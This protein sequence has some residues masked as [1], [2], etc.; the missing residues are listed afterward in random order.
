MSIHYKD[1]ISPALAR[2]ARGVQDK[3]PILEAMGLQLVSL[4]QRAFNEAALRPA[5]WPAK[6]DGTPAT[7][8]KNQVLVRS[9]RITEITTDS[10]TV[11]TDRPYAAIHQRG[12]VIKPK[13]PDGVLVFEIGG[14]K[15][16][17]KRVVMPARPFFPF[18]GD[19]MTDSAQA[20]IRRVAEEKIASLA[21]GTAP[22][23][24]VA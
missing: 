23:G 16:F 20:K 17:A 2:L 8:R 11:A 13:R 9:I 10:V 1:T 19:R 6:R 7:L 15:I 22:G 4:T 14:K 18:V 21:R 5:P 24:A 12:G 3:K